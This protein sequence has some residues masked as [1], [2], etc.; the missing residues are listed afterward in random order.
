[1][2]R[3]PPPF[4]EGVCVWVCVCVGV[5][6]CVCVGGGKQATLPSD[7]VKIDTACGVT[8]STCALG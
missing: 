1:M 6:V 4:Q 7:W 8:I 3:L 2:I 5:C